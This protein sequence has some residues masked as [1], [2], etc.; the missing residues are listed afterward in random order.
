MEKPEQLELDET[1]RN[2]VAL[3]QQDARMPAGDLARA[4]G[5]SRPT[6]NKRLDRLLGEGL[7][8]LLAET[9][10]EASGKQFLVLLG[11]RCELLSVAAVASA[12]AEIEGVLVVET[13]T[14]RFDIEVV[15][16]VE[17][18]QRLNELLTVDIPSIPGVSER[19]PGLC[20]EV[21]KFASNLVPFSA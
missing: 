16:A 20:L 10:I 18:Q 11:V 9:D 12:L 7:L 3:L 14:G 1:D 19:S 4:L 17:S 5:I 2:L 6:V 21:F 13:V 8:H 15:I